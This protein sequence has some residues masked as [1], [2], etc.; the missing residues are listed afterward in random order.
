MVRT[1]RR[2]NRLA[3]GILL[4]FFAANSTGGGLFSRSSSHEKAARKLE[5]RW[6]G[7]RH[8][9]A[10]AARIARVYARLAEAEPALR[11]LCTCH[12]LSSLEPNAFSLAHGRIYITR[13]LYSALT[14]N[15]LLAAALA[16]E[17]SHILARDG[18]TGA[19]TGSV[20]LNQEIAADRRG[21]QIL[22]AAGYRA[23]AMLDLLDRIADVQRPGWAEQRIAAVQAQLDAKSPVAT[24]PADDEMI[25]CR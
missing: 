3:V 1:V 9:P 11:H 14:T 18:L 25:C 6:G 17:A 13:G 23:T 19:V 7:I 16:H 8:D 5:A 22:T 15:D 4:L 2:N 21:M 20:Q 24:A 12:V 10:S